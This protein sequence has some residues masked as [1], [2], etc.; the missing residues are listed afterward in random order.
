MLGDR[1]YKKVDSGVQ[2]TIMAK[3]DEY[4]KANAKEQVAKDNNIEYKN[5]FAGIKELDDPTK[6]LTVNTAFNAEKAKDGFDVIDLLI[7]EIGKMS[8]DDQE[9]LRDKNSSAMMYYDYMNPNAYGY[10]VDS[11]KSVG[12]LKE[13]EKE[14]A[15]KRGADQASGQDTFK[16]IKEGYTSKK[17]SDADVMA[18]MTKQASNGNY[19]VTKG[20]AAVFLAAVAGGKSIEAALELAEA[21]DIDK[22]GTVDEKAVY[23]PGEYE[24]TKVL[25]KAGI[26]KAGQKAYDEIMYPN[27]RGKRNKKNG[28]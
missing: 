26:N 14:N 18:M 23:I 11:S 24:G 25:K 27:G 15:K 8:K 22:D 10:K 4:T 9:Y 13:Q 17:L 5:Q 20:R 16:A 19:D 28:W 6:Y 3:H 2:E 7:P 21:A 12:Y 1:V